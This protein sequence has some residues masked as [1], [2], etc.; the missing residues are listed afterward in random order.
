M[1]EDSLLCFIPLSRDHFSL[2]SKWLQEPH[3][4]QWWSDG[5]VWDF[6]AVATKY[7]S[8]VHSYK[9][10]EQGEKKPIYAFVIACD[11]V[12]I[13]Y[14]QYYNVFDFQRDEFECVKNLFPE[15]CAALDIFL[16]EILYTGK[17]LGSALLKNFL[18]EHVWKHFCACYVDP[19]GE[20]EGAIRAYEKAGFEKIALGKQ[21]VG[22]LQK[23]A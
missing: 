1:V 17:G 20:N 2:L 13:G 12:P 22:M 23:R 4:A 18:E 14:I 10:N 5:T 19:V 11:G 9:I 21:I 15:N 3:V 6:S 8:Y 7:S 16:G